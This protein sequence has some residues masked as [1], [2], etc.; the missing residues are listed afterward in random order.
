MKSVEQQF[1][2]SKEKVYYLLSSH[3]ELL[4]DDKKL[5]ISYLVMYFNLKNVLACA[6]PFR[7]LCD[8]LFKEKINAATVLRLRQKYQKYQRSLSSSVKLKVWKVEKVEKEE[9][10]D[11]KVLYV[12]SRI[13]QLLKNYPAL[14][15]NDNQLWISYL[16]MFHDLKNRLNK[17][18][19]PYEEFCNIVMD[20]EVPSIATIRR[21][22]Q[23]IL[24]VTN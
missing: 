7:A 15:E 16:V 9:K 5:W 13:S 24:N 14:K 20:K 21:S 11:C 12:K 3:P 18:A 8:L 4:N 10:E 2:N 22:R 19:D 1:S 6:E 23:I 17:S